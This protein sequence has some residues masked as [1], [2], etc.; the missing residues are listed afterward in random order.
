[1]S[2][3]NTNPVSTVEA[4]AP[5]FDATCAILM[6]ISSLLTAWSSY[7]NSR[8][9]GRTNDLAAFADRHE[10]EVAAMHLESRQVAATHAQMVMEVVDAMLDGDEKRVK[11]YTDRFTDELKPAYEKWL[12]M[13]PFENTSAPP[14]PFIR[15]YYKPRYEDEIHTISEQAS[16]AREQARVTGR[17]AATYLSNTVLLATVLFF[18]GT[19]GK[20]DKRSVR[21]GSLIFALVLFVYTAVRTIFL[22]VA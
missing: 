20:F 3:K 5:W 2:E 16:Q 17:T 21:R 1:M 22:P 14:H 18:A 8:W 11:F 15:E 6:A 13:K 7:Q 4:K 12:T 9:T 10:R 19:A